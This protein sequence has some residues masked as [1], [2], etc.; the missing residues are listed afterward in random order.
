MSNILSSLEES[1]DQWK[2]LAQH[3]Q[4]VAQAAGMIPT[5]RLDSATTQETSRRA[6]MLL[7]KVAAAYGVSVEQ[8]RGLRRTKEVAEARS[9]AMHLARETLSFTWTQAAGLVNRD[10]SNAIHMSARVKERMESD[11]SFAKWIESIDRDTLSAIKK[12]EN[13]R[14]KATPSNKP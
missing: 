12:S 3:W 11:A 13:N 8:I 7:Q 4:Q 1:R 14:S 2:A 10:H 6:M 5:D 9:V